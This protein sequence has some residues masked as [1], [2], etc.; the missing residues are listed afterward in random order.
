MAERCRL[1]RM[2]ACVASVV[3]VMPQ[4]ICGVVIRSVRKEN[5]TGGSSAGLHLQGVPVDGCLAQPRRRA[6]LEP[7]QSQPEPI[8]PLGQLEG[9]GLAEAAGRDLLLAEVD[10]PVQERAGGQHHG[11]G[12]RCRPSA[13]DH[14]ANPAV[15][16]D[17]VLDAALD[18]LEIGRGADRRLHGLAVELAVGLGARALHG[19]PLGAVEQPELDAGRV[20]HPAHQAVQ[21]IDLAHQMALAEPAD[22]RIA[23]HL[24]D[25]REGMRD[26]RGARAHARRRRRRLAA[27]VAAAH[28]DHIELGVGHR[29]EFPGFRADPNAPAAGIKGRAGWLTR[30]FT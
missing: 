24:A 25:G 14:A 17:Q 23:G 5:G 13:D 22:G 27:G 12:A 8:Q 2:M 9:R 18:D 28:Y 29:S 30:R 3:R 16:D 20:G 19:R 21:G 7:A 1:A 10:Q 15:L 4:V 11:A 26:E 6:G